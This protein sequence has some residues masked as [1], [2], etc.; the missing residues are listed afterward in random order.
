MLVKKE[1]T[2][3]A[4]IENTAKQMVETGMAPKGMTW[5]QL[6][7]CGQRGYELGIPA[8]QAM[9]EVYVI[10][11]KASLKAEL[12]LQ[13]MYKNIPGFRHEITKWTEEEVEAI[14]YSEILQTPAKVSL[15]REYA[16][17]ALWSREIK[18]GKWVNGTDGRKGYY[19]NE[20][21]PKTGEI[22]CVTKENWVKDPIGMLFNRL[23]SVVART[24]FPQYKNA[25]FEVVLSS[26]ETA[27]EAIR[28]VTEVNGTKVDTDTGEVL[29]GDP[30]V[31]A[32]IVDETPKT[33]EAPKPEAPKVEENKSGKLFDDDKKK[34]K[35]EKKDFECEDCKAKITG[36]VMKYS[37]DKLGKALC[38]ECQNTAG[39]K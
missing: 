35:T 21:D 31:D 29:K 9:Q 8:V 17:R 37:I 39:G 7:I 16:D 30:I 11:G 12:Q 10:Q 36:N 34:E 6:A 25:Q 1:D 26:P 5:Q 27:E 14:F 33:E 38:F 4:I 3:V 19:E 18:K 20:K 15:T 2:S 22:V 24:R 28:N 32:E 13:L 23:S